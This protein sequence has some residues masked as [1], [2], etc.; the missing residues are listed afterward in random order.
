[1]DHHISIK[2]FLS[3]KI[4]LLAD[5][6]PSPF[7]RNTFHTPQPASPHTERSLLLHG[8]YRTGSTE[9][10]PARNLGGPEVL[11]V[12]RSGIASP[13]SHRLSSFARLANAGG[14]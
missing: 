14:E 2:E 12:D 9:S 1:M 13:F 8:K 6:S 3:F 10:S 5:C 4:C 7:S 11:G